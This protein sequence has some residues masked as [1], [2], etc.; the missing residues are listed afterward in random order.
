MLAFGKQD[1]DGAAA[2][3]N[4]VVTIAPGTLEAEAAS[5]GLEGINA[6]RGR[7]AASGTTGGN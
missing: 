7:G 1:M 4:Q 2:A 3:W 5:R 6:S